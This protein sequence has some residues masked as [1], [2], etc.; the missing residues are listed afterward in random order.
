[1]NKK[2]TIAM[3]CFNAEATIETSIQSV[4]CQTYNNYEF[5]IIDGCSKDKTLEIIKKYPSIKF[6]SEPDKGIYDAMNKA[7]RIADGDYLLFLGSDDVLYS[8]DIL[9]IV[10]NYLID[11]VVYYGSVIKTNNGDVYDG[12]F[13]KW[14][15]G[16]KNI[17]HQS[18]FYPKSI[19]KNK[20]YNTEYKLVADWVYNLELLADSIKFRYIN[21]VVSFYN[22]IDGLSSTR[23]DE[24]FLKHRRRLVVNAVGYIPYIW[25][26]FNKILKRI[27]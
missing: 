12:Q 7:L 4:L 20:K 17:C 13:S 18:I 2:I 23:V 27:K 11:D 16:Y 25:G 6:I 1:M 19:Y 22:D 3:V 24:D 8:P 5:V 21:E 10:S 14:K 9:N 15:W 26:L